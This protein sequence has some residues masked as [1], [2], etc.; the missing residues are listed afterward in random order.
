MQSSNTEAPR[1]VTGFLESDWP[2][3]VRGGAGT[4][5]A[6]VNTKYQLHSVVTVESSNLCIV[7]TVT[8]IHN[9]C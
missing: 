2:N 5:I 1:H 6:I 8:F 3:S 4:R 7:A 9:G